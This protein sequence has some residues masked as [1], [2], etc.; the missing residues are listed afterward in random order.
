M[1]LEQILI[2]KE[3]LTLKYAYKMPE[4]AYVYCDSEDPSAWQSRCRDKLKELIVCDFDFGEREIEVHH[5]TRIE[6]GTVYSLIMHAD[7]TLSMPAYLFVPDEIKIKTPVIAIQGHGY[8]RG[9]LGLHD[10]YHHGFA[11]DLFRAGCVVL[12]PEIRGFG[13]LVNL[14]ADVEKRGIV[15]YNWGE[16]MAFTLVTDAFLKGY[17]L[18][19]D[20]TQDLY[21][22]GSYLCKRFGREK[23]ALAGISYG[24]DLAVILAA[25]DERVAKT[26]AS[27]TLGS[28]KTIFEKCYNAP[29]HCVPGILKY[30]D[31]QEIA[32]CI[33]PRSLCAHYGALDVPSPENSSAAYNETVMP[34]YDAVKRFYDICGAGD[35]LSLIIS[36]NMNHEMDNDALIAYMQGE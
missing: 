32:S 7:E 17:T 6:L 33:A 13:D 23:Y 36:E 19:G 1:N 14:S 8:V 25:L 27:G 31:R 15:Y 2:P 18:I 20:T 4:K 35:N 3:D 22:W 28:M 5:N 30:M 29:A 10:D 34:A 26:F 21:A 12:V 11:V 9:V 24:G 16:L